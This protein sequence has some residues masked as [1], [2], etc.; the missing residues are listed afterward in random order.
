M[1][2][3]QKEKIKE[4]VEITKKC[5]MNNVEFI[6]LKT[7]YVTQIIPVM[8]S[9]D[10]KTFEDLYTGEIYQAYSEYFTQFMMGVRLCDDYSHYYPVLK[11]AKIRCMGNFIG[12]KGFVEKYYKNSTNQEQ[13]KNEY[14]CLTKQLNGYDYQSVVEKQELVTLAQ[15]MQKYFGGNTQLNKDDSQAQVVL[16]Q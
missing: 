11:N 9:D 10:R 15:D 4:I 8:L 2:A 16:K 14:D 13:I 5:S 1:E 12:T 3:A 7:K 6:A